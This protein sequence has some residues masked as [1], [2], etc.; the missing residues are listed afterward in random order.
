[1]WGC[2]L[3]YCENLKGVESFLDSVKILKLHNFKKRESIVVLR[4]N[5]ISHVLLNRLSPRLYVDDPVDSEGTGKRTHLYSSDYATFA[6][7]LSLD[8][9]FA[10]L[11][12]IA[13]EL[14][15]IQN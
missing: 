7:H 13:T 10:R 5:A 6:V 2:A 14:G 15:A 4:T 11:A 9:P 1:M 3:D 12:A 8:P